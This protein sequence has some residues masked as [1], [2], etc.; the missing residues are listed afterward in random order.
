MNCCTPLYD[1]V[2]DAKRA[3]KEIKAYRKSGLSKQS[4]P[5]L[6]MLHYLPLTD[7]TLLDVGGGFG[8]MS[9]ELLKKGMREATLVD[10]SDHYVQA[11]LNLAEEK[12]F[13]DQVRAV[14]GDLAAIKDQV[15]SSDLVIMDKVICCYANY[16]EL[17]LATCEKAKHYLAYS[18]PADLWWVRVALKV[19]QKWRQL[20]GVNFDTFVHSTDAVEMLVLANGFRKVKEVR[21]REWLY[22]LFERSD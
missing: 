4:L 1:A 7:A 19:S 9:F 16:Q 20:R 12:G 8:G 21:R 6:Q 15:P 14:Q 5:L 18:L 22:V 17:I 13:R 3:A 10:I 11:Y 2:F